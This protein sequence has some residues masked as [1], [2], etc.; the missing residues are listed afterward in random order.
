MN[1]EDSSSAQVPDDVLALIMTVAEVCRSESEP[2]LAFA[3]DQ[4]LH[5][6]AEINKRRRSGQLR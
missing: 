6:L 3:H 4:Y 5:W 1:N 2:S